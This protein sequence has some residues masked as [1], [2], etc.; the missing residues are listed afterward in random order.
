MV[1]AKHEPKRI[2][3]DGKV[4]TAGGVTS[5]IDFG[6]AIVA[7]IAGREVAEATQL[8]IEYDPDP[9]FRSGNPEQASDKIL[10]IVAPRYES[11]RALYSERLEALGMVAT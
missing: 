1:G 5:G 6:L 2:V 7:E 9:P 4:T 11:A 10:A 3:T 8:S